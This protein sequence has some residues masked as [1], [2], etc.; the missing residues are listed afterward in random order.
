MEE[1]FFFS[2]L[3]SVMM[4]KNL[5]FS[6]L[7]CELCQHRYGCIHILGVSAALMVMHM[8]KRQ[9]KYWRVEP[10]KAWNLMRFLRVSRLQRSSTKSMKKFIKEVVITILQ[11]YDILFSYQTTNSCRQTFKNTESQQNI[12][13]SL[14]QHKQITSLQLGKQTN[15]KQWK[16]LHEYKEDTQ[17]RKIIIRTIHYFVIYEFFFRSSQFSS[18]YSYPLLAAPFCLSS[19]V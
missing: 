15:V 17:D 18:Y 2:I 7:I 4:S 5:L 1:N 14:L 11:V 6:H 16:A 9:K 13:K 8:W 3:H 19:C 12:Q 10:R